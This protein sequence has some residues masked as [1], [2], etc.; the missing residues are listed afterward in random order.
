MFQLVHVLLYVF[1]LVH[2]L[3]RHV[4]RL[5]MRQNGF[6]CRNVCEPFVAE[7]QSLLLQ[8]VLYHFVLIIK[9]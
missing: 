9:L 5:W 1:V 8:L 6:D 2:N 3:Y 7:A 4:L